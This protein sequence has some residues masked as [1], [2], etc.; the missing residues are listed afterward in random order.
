MRLRTIRNAAGVVLAAFLFAGRMN[1]AKWA[2][3]WSMGDAESVVVESSAD[4]VHW[5]DVSPPIFTNHWELATTNEPQQFWRLRVA[6]W[7]L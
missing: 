4:L 6:T 2:L 3:D 1:A 5:R 7:K